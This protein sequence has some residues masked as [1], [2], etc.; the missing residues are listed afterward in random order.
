ME[1]GPI[2]NNDHAKELAADWCSKNPGWRFTG[3]WRTTIPDVMSVIDVELS[4]KSVEVGPI[5][6]NDHAQQL[7]HDWCAKNP[8]WKFT[9]DWRTTIPNEMSVIDVVFQTVEKKSIEVGPIFNN[10]HAQQLA[11]EWCNKNPGWK[12][13]GEWNTTVPNVMSVIVVTNG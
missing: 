8:G 5:W 7:A 2:W 12:Y 10:D 4:K 11:S 6:N 9:G 3:D 13:T 1:V